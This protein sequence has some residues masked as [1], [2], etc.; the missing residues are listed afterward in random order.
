[1][2]SQWYILAHTNTRK[3]IFQSYASLIVQNGMV[4]ILNKCYITVT[5][6]KK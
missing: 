3:Y 6:D 2:T 1:M 4:I 5:D